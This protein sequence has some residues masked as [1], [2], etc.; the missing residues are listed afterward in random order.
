FKNRE[1]LL[2]ANR[3]GHYT[4]TGKINGMIVPFLIDTGATEVV[5]PGHLAK[6]LGLVEGRKHSVNTAN[7]II[8]V[9]STKI[10]T[11]DLGP[12]HLRNVRASINPHMNGDILL[13][14]SALSSLDMSQSNN[15]MVL[16]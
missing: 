13:G 4:L 1:I 14:M 8:S 10:N 5:I 7:G 12:I 15:Q 3:H 2:Q 16:R 9:Y 6:D 11:L